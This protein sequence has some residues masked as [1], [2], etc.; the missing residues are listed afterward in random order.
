[1]IPLKKNNEAPYPLMY[2][3]V[4][5]SCGLIIGL[6]LTRLCFF[7]MKVNSENMSPSLSRG[8]LILVNRI[9]STSKGDIV[10]FNSP[11]EEGKLLLGRIIASEFDTVEIRDKRIFI[12][13]NALQLPQR[14]AISMPFPMGFSF[15]DNMPPVKLNRN[16]YFIMGDNLDNSF[17]SR[18]F[19]PIS[20]KLIEGKI[21]YKKSLS[22]T[23]KGG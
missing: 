15:R 14:T 7:V 18:V 23:N 2:K 11:V 21:I 8:E 4:M 1:V 22:K 9:A 5:A 6:I 10:A 19:G 16:E 17:D 12:N 13:G 3:I 20:G